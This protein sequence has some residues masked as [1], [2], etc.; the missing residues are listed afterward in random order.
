MRVESTIFQNHARAS[1][2]EAVSE[3]LN[4]VRNLEEE[5]EVAERK[6]AEEEVPLQ[7]KEVGVEGQHQGHPRKQKWLVS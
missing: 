6:V 4:I 3:R 7:T 2:H 1:S 5:V